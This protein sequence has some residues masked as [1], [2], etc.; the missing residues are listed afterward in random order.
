MIY[1]CGRCQPGCGWHLFLFS[2]LV[3]PAGG[4]TAPDM[5]LSLV[6]IKNLANL[7]V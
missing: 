6:A 4:H 5:P 1:K 2:S 3:F 7:F